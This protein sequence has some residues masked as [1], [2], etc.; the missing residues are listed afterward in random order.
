[1]AS[2]QRL[3]GVQKAAPSCKSR[4]RSVAARSLLATPAA[5]L[6]DQPA[7]RLAS[8]KL[9]RP[10]RV[11]VPVTVGSRGSGWLANVLCG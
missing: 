1:M 11:A 5:A 7:V 10:A 8:R 2:G 6:V 4:R 9:R 3:H